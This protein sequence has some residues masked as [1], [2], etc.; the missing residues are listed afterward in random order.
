MNTCG[1]AKD[2]LPF[3]TARDAEKSLDSEGMA[4]IYEKA[5]YSGAPCTEDDV[6]RMKKY[7]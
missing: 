3:Y 1:L 6:R 4:A 2:R 7:V 5:R